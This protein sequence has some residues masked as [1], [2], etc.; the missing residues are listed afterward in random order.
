MPTTIELRALYENLA[1]EADTRVTNRDWAAAARECA[2]PPTTPVIRPHGRRTLRIGLAAA[3]VAMLAAGATLAAGEL[4]PTGGPSGGGSEWPVRFLPFGAAAGSGWTVGAKSTGSDEPGATFV[5]DQLHVGMD[6]ISSQA[7]LQEA[8]ATG[9]Q[10]AIGPFVGWYIGARLRQVVWQY[11]PDHIAI[12]TLTRP[13]RTVTGADA[14]AAVLSA[15]RAFDPSATT[16]MKTAFKVDAAPPGGVLT[17]VAESHQFGGRSSSVTWTVSEPPQWI[18]VTVSKTAP[19]RPGESSGTPI[20]VAG[21]PAWWFP[22]NLTISLGSGE[23]LYLQDG[24]D[25]T[26]RSTFTE[27]QMVDFASHITLVKNVDDGSTWFDA[28]ALP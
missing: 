21:R 18:T 1:A 12:A 2:E 28:T 8:E 25:D 10:V 22:R 7:R 13:R 19:T 27:Q 9:Q 3:T 11:A 14:E 26:G 16:Q 6:V 24:S 15:A 23:S 17:D 5:R 4:H 20:T